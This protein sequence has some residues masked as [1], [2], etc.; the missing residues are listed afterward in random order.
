MQDYLID[1]DVQLRPL[2]TNST[3]S[4]VQ[5]RPMGTKL[6]GVK[7]PRMDTVQYAPL[8]V[9]L[10][11]GVWPTDIATTALILAVAALIIVLAAL[12]LR[13]WTS[14]EHDARLRAERQ[15]ALS[16]KLH[17]L[18]AAVSRARTPARVIEDSV[19]EFLH[20]VDGAAAAFILL[21]DGG[22]SGEIVRTAAC[23]EPFTRS[24]FPLSTYPAL[25]HV[26]ERH[27]IGSFDAEASLLPR[28]SG[29]D[30]MPGK[31]LQPKWC[32]GN[33]TEAPSVVARANS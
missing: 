23:D 1:C 20:A 2:A 8:P 3:Q 28:L 11:L 5:S 4:N 16:E 30:R 26:A 12:R 6:H 33:R 7:R 18:V 25:G 19:P 32:F 13:R 17:Q 15:A 21:G 29:S 10:L 31:F 14:A 24:P 22:R 9:A 27:A